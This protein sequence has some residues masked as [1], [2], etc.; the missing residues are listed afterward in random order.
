MP[1]NCPICDRP[2]DPERDVLY[3]RRY[4]SR[5]IPSCAKCGK[6]VDAGHCDRLWRHATEVKHDDSPAVWA[7]EADIL[8][9]ASSDAVA[10]RARGIWKA[11]HID[12]RYPGQ[13]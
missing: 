4:H 12:C 2:I 10:T 8:E 13:A 5:C 11:V 7:T 1:P 6:P 9:L 3:G